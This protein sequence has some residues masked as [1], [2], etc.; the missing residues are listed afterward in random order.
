[1]KIALCSTSVPFVSGGYR[2]IVEWLEAMLQEAGHA[3]EKVYLPMVDS[4]ETLFEQMA[5]FRYLDLSMADRI[6][7]FRPQSHLIRHPH[8]ILWFI[9][10][11]RAFY[12]LWGHSQYCPWPENNKYRGVRDALLQVDTAALKEAQ[13]VFANSKVIANRLQHF[14]G[15]DSEVLY[16]P[17]FQPER[18]LWEESNDE[19]VCICRLEHHKRQHLLVEAMR[20]TRTPVK[21]RLCGTG[22]QSYISLLTEKIAAWGLSDKIRFSP[23]WI[24]E[25]DKVGHVNRCLAAAYMPLD[26]DSY[27]YPSVEASLAA[28]PVLT[29]ADAGGVGELVQHG[30]NGFVAEPD[31]KA[32]AGMM[33]ALY[34][35]RQ[36][37]RAMGHNAKE[38]LDEL[39]IS[40]EH[41]LE[42]LLA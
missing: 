3:V 9:H 22:S 1:M 7:C 6:I 10:H 41:V 16:P 15:I 11:I 23:R 31:P 21:L 18:F 19:I 35:D 13:K 25:E 20:Y 38:R 34:A 5:A 26:E 37:S 14:N 42:R 33:D 27:G 17:V 36:V 40:W 29:C 39:G 12:D 30:C 2:N 8:K 28:K 32:I 4:P 24:S